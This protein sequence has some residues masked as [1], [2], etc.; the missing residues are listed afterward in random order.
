[1]INGKTRIEQKKQAIEKVKTMY[2]IDVNDD[3][4]E[5]ILLGKYSVDCLRKE[6]IKTLF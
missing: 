6:T 5:A 1:M 4:A 2:G 3:V